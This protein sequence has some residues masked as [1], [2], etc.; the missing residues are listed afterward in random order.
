MAVFASLLSPYDPNKPD[1]AATWGTRK[2]ALG[3]D[4]RV[5][6]GHSLPHHLGRPASL[7]VGMISVGGALLAGSLIGLVAG[8]LAGLPIRF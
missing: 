2:G 8:T 4:G 5:G 1:Y 6:P 7:L 3:R